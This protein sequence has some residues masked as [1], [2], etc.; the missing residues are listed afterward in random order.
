M[1][2][3]PTWKKVLI[4]FVCLM[5]IVYAAPNFF[6]EHMFDDMP[7]FAPGRTLNLGLDL[8]GGSH[9]LLQVETDAVLSERLEAT[10][11]A[12]R[13]SLYGARV[14]YT[15]LKIDGDIV[16]FTLRDAAQAEQAIELIRESDRSLSIEQPAGT[17]IVVSLPEDQVREIRLNAVEQSV[18]IIRRRIDELGTREPNIQ[19]QGVDRIIVQVP[20][21]DDP[22]ALKAVIGTTA[23]MTFHLL[24][25]RAPPGT[26]PQTAPPGAMI[27]PSADEVDSNGDPVRYLV[28]R[29]VR[30]SG[31]RLVD[32]QP[33]FQ[34]NFPVV[35]FRFDTLGGQQ[36]GRTTQENPRRFLAIVLDGKVIS[37]PR[38]NE[39]ILGGSGIITGQ[40]S[41]K[42]VNDLSLLL[43]AGALP[44]P[45]SFLEE[46]TVGPGL[47][48]DSVDAGKVASAVGLVMVVVFMVVSYGRFGVMADIALV[49]NIGLIIAV[50]SG[51]QATLTLPGIAGIVL[52]VGM[53]VDANVLIFE[54]IREEVENGRSPFNAVEAGY[55]GALTTII[56]S[57]LTT[58]IAAVLLFAF[59]AGPIKGFA[60][61]LS[62]G[63]VTS[64]FTAIMVTRLL[65]VMWLRKTR[66]EKLVV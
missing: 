44:A 50:L 65:V 12:I 42:E 30:V 11:D 62:I 64:M 57:N 56:D 46:R 3:F 41:V 34:D 37:A 45:I 40:F 19:R 54:R 5:G 51:L 9:L 33:S 6:P 66:P 32:S 59:G 1:L 17:Q 36:F 15:N 20:G 27:L 52:T 58:L 4:G 2:N 26:A 35:S 53:A 28:E 8:Q 29:R 23:K 43:R 63:I 13:R 7:D 61:T 10:E 55:R 16:S 21:F 38:I 18:E 39:P 22:E 24:D 47:G 14:G 60:V 48:Q 31:E 49:F 25:E